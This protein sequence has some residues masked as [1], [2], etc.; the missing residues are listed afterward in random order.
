MIGFEVANYDFRELSALTEGSVFFLHKL[1]YYEHWSKVVRSL[2]HVKRL[3]IQ[4]WWFK[5]FA[6]EPAFSRS[7]LKTLKHL[8]LINSVFKA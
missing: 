5:L 1:E 6:A 8:E 3:A 4:N 7:S 2:L